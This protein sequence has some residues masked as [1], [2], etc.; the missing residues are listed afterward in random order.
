MNWGWGGDAGEFYVFLPNVL[1]IALMGRLFGSREGWSVEG[2]TFS[3][4][5]RD[6]SWKRTM[7]A[8]CNETVVGSSGDHVR[9]VALIVAAKKVDCENDIYIFKTGLYG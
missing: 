6:C 8:T 1:M 5:C 3:Q 9:D 4:L 2:V 7:A